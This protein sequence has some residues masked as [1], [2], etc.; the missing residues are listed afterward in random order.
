MPRRGP[1]CVQ[2]RELGA[3]NKA[4]APSPA[5]PPLALTACV[6]VES[7]R[8]AARS[9]WLHKPLNFARGARRRRP[10]RRRLLHIDRPSSTAVLLE[11]ALP[12]EAV[13]EG[14]DTR[15]ASDLSSRLRDGGRGPGHESDTGDAC[16]GDRKAAAL[17]SAAGVEIGSRGGFNKRRISYLAKSSAS[18]TALSLIRPIRH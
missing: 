12:L 13:V 11:A 10:P 7:P 1:A 15:T 17:S 16:L 3:G 18:A 6:T 5:Q 2:Q 9:V 8:S 4:A 14:R